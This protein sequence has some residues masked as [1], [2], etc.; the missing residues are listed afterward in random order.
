MSRT[1]DFLLFLKD[2]GLFN[3][4]FP[5]G[6]QQAY[7][8]RTCYITTFYMV[9]TFWTPISNQKGP[10]KQGQSVLPSIF[11]FILLSLQALELYHWFFLNFGMVLET[12][13]YEVVHSRAGFFGGKICPKNWENGPRMVQKLFFLNLLKNLVINFY[14]ICSLVNICIICCVPKILIPE[15]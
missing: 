8:H 7:G 2:I 13:M 12:C 3:F 14:R 4:I 11:L 6:L 5:S 9:C 10:I 1:Q 15:I